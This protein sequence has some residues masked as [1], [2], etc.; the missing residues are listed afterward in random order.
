MVSGE[1]FLY[2]IDR[3]DW[4]HKY[5]VIQEEKNLLTVKIVKESGRKIVKDLA[6]IETE[7]RKV[8]GPKMDVQFQFV[9]EIP[10]ESSGKNSLVVSHVNSDR[11]VMS[12]VE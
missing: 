4:V 1:V 5:K 12:E 8:L 7:I 3:F 2:I 6:R 10:Q 11:Y 9:D